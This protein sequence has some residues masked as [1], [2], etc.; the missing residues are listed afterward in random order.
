MQHKPIKIRTC[1]TVR[2]SLCGTHPGLL[3]AALTAVAIFVPGGRG[4]RRGRRR[5]DNDW[6]GGEE[7]WA[8]KWGCNND[9]N[10]YD[11]DNV[12]WSIRSNAC[13]I[14]GG[15]IHLWG[16]L[17]DY[18]MYRDTSPDTL[19]VNIISKSRLVIVESARR[20]LHESTSAR[21]YSG[22]HFAITSTFP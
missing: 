18:T 10:E 9:D 5:E 3:H 20:P 14:T 15:L 11:A 6:R 8:Q 7:E 17:W 13:I 2:A 4:R 1:S 12:G 22:L 19:Y 21:W 16:A